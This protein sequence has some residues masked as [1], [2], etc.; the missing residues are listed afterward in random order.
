M[1]WRGSEGGLTSLEMG[2]LGELLLLALEG[3][4]VIQEMSCRVSLY[5]VPF[6]SFGVLSRER[7]GMHRSEC[8]SLNSAQMRRSSRLRC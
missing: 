1:S 5:S 4:H 7:A 8:G 6:F 3:G 2:L